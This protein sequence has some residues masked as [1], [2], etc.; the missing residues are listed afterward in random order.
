MRGVGGRDA[1][2]RGRPGR[3]PGAG[4]AEVERGGHVL[5]LGSKGGGGSASVS[6]VSRLPVVYGARCPGHGA[7]SRR[8][9]RLRGASAV[10]NTGPACANAPTAALAGRLRS[11]SLDR[12]ASP[13]DAMSPIQPW[14]AARRL[15]VLVVDD[16]PIRRRPHDARGHAGLRDRWP[17]RAT[18]RRRWGVAVAAAP[19]PDGPAAARGIS[20]VEATRRL[21][22]AD[23]GVRIVVVS[24]PGGRRLDLRRDAGAG[25]EPATSSGERP[26]RAVLRDAGGVPWR[27]D[28]RRLDRP[29]RHGVHVLRAA[30]M[31]FPELTDRER[32]ILER[33]AHW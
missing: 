5:L 7:M 11:V 6:V 28:L 24:M 13:R 16:H 33:I 1:D 4:L 26:R 22:A 19:D 29:P 8:A 2:R 9:G 20:G 17:R 23:P 31:A 14:P 18:A 10:R 21:V 32:E 15:R 27:G 3:G 25:A 30:A 12:R